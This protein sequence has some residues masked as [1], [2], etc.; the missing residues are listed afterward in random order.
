MRPTFTLYPRLIM[1]KWHSTTSL[2][3]II[4]PKFNPHH[5]DFKLSQPWRVY[6]ILYQL[7]LVKFSLRF[8]TTRNPKQNEN[9]VE[10]EE[11][12]RST[13]DHV[14]LLSVEESNIQMDS[15]TS[16]Y[17]SARNGAS[18][19]RTNKISRITFILVT[20]K[21]EKMTKKLNVR[22]DNHCFCVWIFPPESADHFLGF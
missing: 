10:P 22:L 14:K 20:E 1:L 8:G 2:H 4:S 11:L 21:R 6:W 13:Q 5:F 3:A 18:N 15:L 9:Q 17:I 16:G 12:N 19:S 7:C